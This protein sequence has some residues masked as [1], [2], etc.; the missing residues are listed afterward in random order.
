MDLTIEDAD[1]I[2]ISLPYRDIPGEHMQRELPHWN[3]FEICKVELTSGDIGFGET[4]TYYSWGRTTD[5]ELSFATGKNALSIMWDDTMGPGLQMACFDAV[6]RALDV[7]SYELLGGKVNEQT[8]I[9]WW[10]I[11][12]PGDDWVKEANIAREQGYTNIKVK[13][14]PWFDIWDQLETL[15]RELPEDFAVD[16]D[17]NDTLLD[18]DRAIP[19]LTEIEEQYPQLSHIEG[20]LPHEDVTGNSK[21]TKRLETPTVLHY[22]SYD[23]LETITASACD[24]FVAGGGIEVLTQTESVCHM[25]KMPYWLQLVGT[26]LTAAFSIQ[27]GAAFEQAK[28]PAINCHQLFAEQILEED[29]IVQNGLVDIPERPGIGFDVD[30]DTVRALEV[31]PFTERPNPKRLIESDWQDGPTFYVTEGEVNFMLNLANTGVMPYFKKGVNTRLIPNDGSERWDG[32]YHNA[33]HE[34][35]VVDESLF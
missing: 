33:E 35:Y 7:P 3:L 24:G 22:G 34:P 19:L 31:E 15:D 5:E 10:C 14:R 28:W 11:D 26:D 21:I 4:M 1:I 13:T 30:M 6:G 16:V 27:C 9:S 2:P 25:A 18:A 23:P 12:M 17:F 20:P 29:I 8:P 32:V